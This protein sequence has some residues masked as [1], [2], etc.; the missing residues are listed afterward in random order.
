MTCVPGGVYQPSGL[1]GGDYFDYLSLA[2]EGLRCVIGDV[3][4]H[5]ARAAFVM[6]MV[7]TVFHFQEYQELAL[8]LLLQRLN[9]KIMQTVGA[10]GDFVT[11]FAADI[12][13]LQ[14]RLEYVNAGH[15]P[16]FF[17][18]Q[19]GRKELEPTSPLLGVLEDEFQSESMQ[20]HGDWE[21]LLYT[22]GCYECRLQNGNIFGYEPFWEICFKL[23]SQGVLDLQALPHEVAKAAPELVGFNDDLTSLHVSGRSNRKAQEPE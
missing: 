8:P 17:Q 6:A 15:C 11:L 23:I 22:D 10:E 2:G 14:G 1:A 7:R 5:G 20:L 9:T 19:A 16:G 12:Q 3:S 21:L 18:D 4:G 13:P